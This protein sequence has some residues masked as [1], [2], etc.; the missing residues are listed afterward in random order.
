MGGTAISEARTMM[1]DGGQVFSSGHEA[2]RFAY[3][4]NAQ[5]YPMTIMGRMMRGSI[6]GSGRG[7]HG[8]DGAAIAGSVKRV[9]E[10]LPPNYRRA[11][12]CRYAITDQE[13]ERAFP[14][15]LQ[16][17]LASLGTGVHST[18]L[19]LKLI[20]RHFG[21]P[22]AVKLASL[23]DEHSMDAATVTRRWQRVH[24]R[25][26]EMESGAACAADDALVKAGLV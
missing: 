26:R 10:S 5:Q 11:I 6:L 19:V 17:A 2:L 22:Q 3:A 18:R 16:P 24:A 13:F 21:R 4:Y 7:L 12:E 25:L 15:L 8:L 14:H 9:V 1:T 23:A 20:C